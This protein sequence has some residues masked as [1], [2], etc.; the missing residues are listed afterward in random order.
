MNA[1][2]CDSYR[3]ASGYINP[4]SVAPSCNFHNKPM[5]QYKIKIPLVGGV[6][7]FNIKRIPQSILEHFL[8]R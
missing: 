5:T 2:D 6:M 3:F 4:L 1:M 7:R 8:N